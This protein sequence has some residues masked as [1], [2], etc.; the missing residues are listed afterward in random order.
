MPFVSTRSLIAMGRPWSGPGPRPA[1]RAASARSACSRAAS[2]TSVTI[3]LTFGLMRSIWRRCASRTSRAVTSRARSRRASSTAL[4]KQSSDG[5]PVRAARRMMP[6]SA[7][8]MARPASAAASGLEEERQVEAVGV[9]QREGAA[10]P[11]LI[12]R[13][14][15]EAEPG[16]LRPR[17]ERVDVL[18]RL[19][20][21]PDALALLAV[22][23]LLP[24]VLRQPELAHARLQHHAPEDVPVGPPLAHHEAEDLGVERDAL[25]EIG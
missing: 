5:S 19:A 12:L 8:P 1:R 24:V 3:A 13:L 16:G 4:L 22:A 15:R 25:P 20:P 2:A 17:R 21:D 23:S 11:G 9:V 7:S 6:S 18:G 14:L 10:A